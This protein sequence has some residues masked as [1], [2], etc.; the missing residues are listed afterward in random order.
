MGDIRA[1]CNNGAQRNFHCIG[2]AIGRH[3]PDTPRR[4]KQFGQKKRKPDNE[5]EQEASEDYRERDRIT[6]KELVEALQFIAKPAGKPVTTLNERET[7][8]ASDLPPQ[9]DWRSK[10]EY[11]TDPSAIDD[12]I[13]R[14]QLK[15]QVVRG[16]YHRGEPDYD[17][18]DAITLDELRA[19]LDRMNR[20]DVQQVR[21][22]EIRSE[23]DEA[24][25]NPATPWRR[26]PYFK[27]G[28]AGGASAAS[29][30]VGAGATVGE[31]IANLVGAD[32]TAD[33]IRGF[34]DDVNRYSD[35]VNQ[36]TEESFKDTAIPD[37]IERAGQSALNTAP[38]MMATGGAG[39]A[40][41]MI[42]VTGLESYDN[43][44]TEGKDF[45]L[46]EEGQRAHAAKMSAVEV[47]VTSIFQRF[48][49]G[50]EKLFTKGGTEPFKKGFKAA[51]K[52]T[53]IAT[54]QEL[55]EELLVE[56]L[57]AS[58]RASDV[59]PTAMD[60]DQ[61]AQTA[62]DT[63]TATI[64]TM[65][66]GGAIQYPARRLAS[67]QNAS[68]D[69]RARAVTA[70]PQPLQRKPQQTDVDEINQRINRTLELSD[71]Q[72]QQIVTDVADE[73]GPDATEE[74]VSEGVNRL[75]YF[76]EMLPVADTLQQRQAAPESPSPEQ[77]STEAQSPQPPETIAQ[78]PG[79]DITGDTQPTVDE[80]QVSSRYR[81]LVSEFE[82]SPISTPDGAKIA[83]ELADIEAK[84]PELV[85]RIETELD[86]EGIDPSVAQPSR[87]STDTTA[88]SVT[89]EVATNNAPFNSEA[90]DQS[91]TETSEQPE[92]R[93][94]AIRQIEQL[95]A[96]HEAEAQRG[97]DTPEPVAFTEGIKAQSIRSY[98][99][100]VESGV[101]P[102]EAVELGKA[103]ASEAIAKH[104]ARRPND[105]SWQR[106]HGAA[107]EAIKTAH[108]TLQRAGSA[109]AT[110]QPTS[111]ASTPAPAEPLPK[112]LKQIGSKR[113]GVTAD[114][115][116]SPPVQPKRLKRI[117]EKITAK[118]DPSQEFEPL[119]TEQPK[120]KQIGQ[121]IQQPTLSD[122]QAIEQATE[123]V[124]EPADTR[125]GER[126]LMR[127][128]AAIADQSDFTPNELWHQVYA[129]ASP[130]DIEAE[131][132]TE[133]EP[134]DSIEPSTPRTKRKPSLKTHKGIGKAYA[135]GHI[136]G[137]QAI[138]ALDAIESKPATSSP[139][140]EQQPTD[141]SGDAAPGPR[142]KK[143][144]GAKR[145]KPTGED[146]S[147]VPLV[148]ANQSGKI[149]RNGFT[150]RAATKQGGK[151]IRRLQ[152]DIDTGERRVGARSIVDFMLDGFA[153]SIFVTKSQT[154]GKHPALFR[155]SGAVVFSRSG[156]WQ[157]NLHEGGHAMDLMLRDRFPAWFEA[158]EPELR[159]FVKEGRSE[160]GS[161]AA[162]FASS[163]EPEEAIAEIVRLY[164]VDDSQVPPTLLRSFKRLVEAASPEAMAT[165]N[166]TKLAYE[167]HAGR[168]L[169][170]RRVADRNDK[171]K[172]Q[173]ASQGAIDTAWTMLTH[174]VG[175]SPILHR[176]RRRV[177]QQV[178]GES[179]TAQFDPTGVVGSVAGWADR[180]HRRRQKIADE[181]L[182]SLDEGTSNIETAYQNQLRRQAVKMRAIGGSVQNEGV[183]LYLHGDGF[184]ALAIDPQTNQELLDQLE[185]AGF[186]LP[187]T[188]AKHGEGQ[189]FHSKSYSQIKSMIPDSE[190]QD[191]QQAFLDRAAI[192]R[193]RKAG[194]Q[195]PG[196]YEGMSIDEIQ[197]ENDQAF[198]QHPK[199]SEVAD[200]IQQFMDQLL[201]I[202]VVSGNLTVDDAI[203][204]KTKWEHYAP[205]QRQMDD[206]EGIGGSSGTEP[207]F[208]IHTAR[209]SMREYQD[210]DTSVYARVSKAIDG[211]HDNALLKSV[212]DYTQKVS[213]DKR[214][215]YATRKDIERMMVPLKMDTL[216]SAQVS[217]AEQHEIV[218]D[219]LNRMQL[220]VM[221]QS[222]KG[223]TSE[224]V[225]QRLQ[226]LGG[227]IADPDSIHIAMPGKP[228]FRKKAPNVQNVVTMWEGGTRR[229]YM[230]SDPVMFSLFTSTSGAKG[231]VRFFSRMA[232]G[233]TEPWKRAYTNSFKFLV[234]NLVRD[235]PTAAFLSK[236]GL[237]MIPGFYTASAMV[238]RLNGNEYSMEARD[239][240]ELMVKSLDATTRDKHK[241]RVQ[242]ARDVLL[243]GLVVPGFGSLSV[244]DKV[245]ALPGVAMSTV[246]KPVDLFNFVTGTRWLAEQTESLAREGAYV[247]ARKRGKSQADAHA[248]YDKISGNFGQRQADK[249]AADVIRAAGFLNPSLQVI[250]QMGEA[251]T[252]ASPSQRLKLNATRAGYLSALG[253]VA[254][255][256]NYLLIHSLFGD[257][258][259]ELQAVLRNMREREESERLSNMAV[260]GVVRLP[261]DYGPA[262]SIMSFS[263]NATE[264]H[265]L[266][267]RVDGTE[268]AKELLKRAAELPGFD[269]VI[270]P[271]AKVNYELWNNWSF[272]RDREIVPRYLEKNY[273]DNP[274]LQFNWYTP[275]LYRDIGAGLNVSPMKVQ[276]AVRG[277]TTAIVDDTV[278]FFDKAAKDGWEI[279]DLPP[280]AGLTTWEATGHRSRSVNAVMDLGDAYD[281]T[282]QVLEQYNRLSQ[283]DRETLIEKRRGLQLA[284]AVSDRI[285]SLADDVSDEQ[286]RA[287]PDHERIESLSSE[288]TRIAS[289]FYHSDVVDVDVLAEHFAK[290]GETLLPYKRGRTWKTGHGQPEPPPRPAMSREVNPSLWESYD[291][292]MAKY[293]RR[294]ESYLSG[295]EQAEEFTSVYLD[296]L[297]KNQGQR[298]VDE[299]IGDVL[300]SD[301][302]RDLLNGRGRPQYDRAKY[303]RMSDW[304]EDVDAW[305]KARAAALELRRGIPD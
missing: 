226:S 279:Q 89:A 156:S 113:P 116:P 74:A 19:E 147:I 71:E 36:V 84:H 301:D 236:D 211:Y 261:F 203:K 197:A 82:T 62:F 128:V 73:V 97:G 238:G 213:N 268:R 94:V 109:P 141:T 192:E 125:D 267:S 78:E 227:T 35:A 88:D 98:V 77:A 111:Q 243:E 264:D 242:Y 288:M 160:D 212:V 87:M 152:R 183:R 296:W 294:V 76:P 255:A 280:I 166:D 295:R 57:Q 281:A 178:A 146:R 3:M 284:K 142:I 86:A 161:R 43:A 180:A 235:P 250:Y 232:T 254:A 114:P 130:T 251:I 112:R 163:M 45:G 27:K 120:L 182:A 103:E 20:Q 165:L 162:E 75:G 257:D 140:P 29:T 105:E 231:A 274:S 187:E 252:E 37:W 175:K 185:A 204:I 151:L 47:G 143:Q 206:V 40:R 56:L 269:E 65:G 191:F 10:A 50:M 266:G 67:Q 79:Q 286:R 133:P 139:A 115:E 99:Q 159:A 265:L 100:R 58:V 218:S 276:Y 134:A 207:R 123:A 229:Y 181:V 132:A 305:S 38:L 11:S 31:G 129:E 96:E 262:G 277:L 150:D 91:T 174:V 66:F 26:N 85:D 244:A 241:T 190:W 122:E 49:P 259:E 4:L 215:D 13:E 127:D 273:A 137:E 52:Q 196:I 32:E 121:R 303:K 126:A 108:Q 189:Q 144:I 198:Q 245:S 169:Q 239:G 173:E 158:M 136:T 234:R 60:S 53:T 90:K 107:N 2:T 63:T 283:S 101:D 24:M 247:R 272:Y 55:P 153:S 8:S 278:K 208:G 201:L 233:M 117:G 225:R 253:S 270:P 304:R 131:L 80:E 300:R 202:S 240:A 188:L 224:Q 157:I 110:S 25:N 221:G 83:A 46:D 275:D 290:Q 145:K 23:V 249:A 167:I 271:H 148:S 195:M 42:G 223:L 61:I 194:H 17:T 104:N 222:A 168:S 302:F 219:A 138:Q 285:E 5:P 12:A 216:P 220:E 14:H 214:I 118:P 155:H 39:G 92:P 209:G 184:N 44:M 299:A 16:K 7:I 164:I 186:L 34:S 263:Y 210:L 177:Y 237:G 33:S 230:V 70:S 292:S 59:D 81:S 41:A 246:M 18:T 282:T 21:Q 102:V 228:L 289:E 260:L 172:S 93:T 64:A 199:W 193:H 291:L 248:L 119:T 256:T 22:N 30:I 106:W 9:G 179:S 15:Q 293:E 95:A 258:E 68:A 48:A 171:P 200:E 6:Q 298:A 51:V 149:K 217:E 1:L 135:D 72:R 124:S 170:D 154:T 28:W 54:G 69:D 287:E 176:L 297:S 205:L